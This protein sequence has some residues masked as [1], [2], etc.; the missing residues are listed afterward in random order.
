MTTLLSN[1]R[2]DLALNAGGNLQV[3]DGIEAIAQAA[4]S[5]MQARLGEMY[6]NAD[7]GIPFVD[8]VWSGAPNIAQFEAAGRTRLMQ[9]PGVIEVVSFEARQVG[10][11]LGYTAVIRTASGETTLNG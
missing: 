8:I 6:Y 4:R 2:N 10:D 7:Q 9:V 1:S 5:Y 3:I 11:V